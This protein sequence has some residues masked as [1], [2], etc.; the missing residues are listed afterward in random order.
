MHVLLPGAAWVMLSKTETLFSR[1]LYIVAEVHLIAEQ[2]RKFHRGKWVELD[3]MFYIKQ[4]IPSKRCHV[5]CY[6]A[7]L[8]NSFFGDQGENLDRWMDGN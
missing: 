4:N 6:E 7:E 2:L 5:V 8:A 1:P 3:K